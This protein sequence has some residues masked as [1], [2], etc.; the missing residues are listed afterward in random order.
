MI[1]EKQPLNMCEANEILGSVKETDKIKDTQIFIK[2]FC[3]TKPESAKKVK[4]I[5]KQGRTVIWTIG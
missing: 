4:R 2:K 3:K 1:K 5:K